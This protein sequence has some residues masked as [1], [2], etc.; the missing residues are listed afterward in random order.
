MLK[1]EKSRL[2]DIL[3]NS[4]LNENI[5]ETELDYITINNL[6]NNAEY[7]TKYD[8]WLNSIQRNKENMQMFSLFESDSFSGR[9]IVKTADEF[10][11]LRGVS[12]SLGATGAV[13][14]FMSFSLTDYFMIAVLLIIVMS[15]FEERKAGLSGIIHAAPRGRARLALQRTVILFGVSFVGVLLLYGSNLAIGFS[16]YGGTNDLSRAVQS[17]EILGKLPMLCSVGSFLIYYL[18]LRVLASFFIGLLFWLLLSAVNNVKYSIII[19]AVILAVEYSLY[20]FLPVQS[21]WNGLKYF[22]LFTYISLSNLYTNYLNINLFGFPFG[23]RNISQFALFPLCMILSAACVFIYCNKKPV[24]GKDVLGKI[25]YC[26]RAITDKV[27][28]RFGLLGTEIYKT[29]WIQKGVIIFAL[30]VYAVFK[31]SFSANISLYS[32]AEVAKQK[33]IG[34]LSGEITDETFSKIDSIMELLDKSIS[35]YEI[36]KID[37]ENGIITKSQ[38]NLFARDEAAASSSKEGLDRVRARVNELKTNGADKGFTPWLIDETPFESVYGTAAQN[39]QHRAAI[40]AVLA[41]TLLLGG[42]IA[43][44]KRSNMTFLSSSTIRGRGVLLSRKILLSVIVSAVIWVVVYGRELYVLMTKFDFSEWDIAVQNLSMLTEFS[45]HC[46]IRDFLIILYAY[47]LLVL[48]CGA[49][50]VLLISSLVKRPEL[51]YIAACG[52]MMLP[53]VLYAYMD[54]RLLKPLAY[55]VGVEGMPLLLGENGWVS[56]FLLWGLVLFVIAGA[57]GAYMLMVTNKLNRKGILKN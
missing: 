43:Y 17:V 41:I 1:Q 22:N 55:I 10:E 13:N 21:V 49:M 40:I 54:V 42:C 28:C 4:E 39:N 48:I 26:V 29:L 11:K 8:D 24:G 15:F 27:L 20:T 31:L 57:A 52:V 6:L 53:S 25:A 2:T 14:A 36:A 44:E 35:D 16:V 9:N 19:A 34:E 37:F 50:I 3:R 18:I 33:Y 56:Q 46:S 45:I 30:F 51:A 7:L 5:S 38:L 12:L 23:I 32:A 47:R